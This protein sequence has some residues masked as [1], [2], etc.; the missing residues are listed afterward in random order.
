M[1]DAAFGRAE[2]TVSSGSTPFTKD[3]PQLAGMFEFSGNVL[4][5]HSI[6]QG[7]RLRDI[8]GGQRAKRLE[9]RC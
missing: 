8:D 9:A 7:C 2:S 5:Y 6:G 3:S 1:G 4:A